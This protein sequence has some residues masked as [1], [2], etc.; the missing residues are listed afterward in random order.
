MSWFFLQQDLLTSTEP[1]RMSDVPFTDAQIEHPIQATG[2]AF[3]LENDDLLRELLDA[4][5][6][7]DTKFKHKTTNTDGVTALIPGGSRKSVLPTETAIKRA[8]TD[9]GM[10]VELSLCQ[11]VVNLES[12]AKQELN[13][14]TLLNEHR[15]R[16]AQTVMQA[17]DL[18]EQRTILEAAEDQFRHI[19][20]T[21][22]EKMS[23]N[24]RVKEIRY[25][26]NVLVV[27]LHP[28]NIEPR[29]EPARQIGELSLTISLLDASI[30]VSAIHPVGPT[31]HPCVSE[32]GFLMLGSLRDVFI[33]YLGTM[34]YAT[35]LKLLTDFL[36]SVPKT[37]TL[38]QRLQ[39]WPMVA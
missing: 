32:N 28:I 30:Q 14:Q 3:Y 10:F 18:K 37:D 27:H 24:S 17:K 21:E 31:A 12:L 13:T 38:R 7:E 6:L 20:E 39:R 15:Q 26:K 36:G 9:S 19:V 35:A 11:R 5:G 8:K 4:L 33:R 16:F 23:Q 25:G 22:C 1:L 29:N 34:Q 2:I